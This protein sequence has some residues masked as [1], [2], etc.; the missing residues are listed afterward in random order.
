M[1]INLTFNALTEA[2]PKYK[3]I[4]EL[5]SDL[6]RNDID[7][8]AIGGCLGVTRHE[9]VSSILWCLIHHFETPNS[10]IKDFWC[11]NCDRSELLL[12]PREGLALFEDCISKD[13]NAMLITGRAAFIS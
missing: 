9:H 5:R 12:K 3:D 8:D 11:E 4:S 6:K 2:F 13:H 7:L 1:R 10:P